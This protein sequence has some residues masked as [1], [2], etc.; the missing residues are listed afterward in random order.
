MCAISSRGY[1]FAR[2]GRR[3]AAPWF[4]DFRGLGIDKGQPALGSVYEGLR[5]PFTNVP[6]N[7]VKKGKFLLGGLPD[8][9]NHVVS[10]EFSTG[11]CCVLSFN[12]LRRR[13]V[14]SS[15]A[16]SQKVNWTWLGCVPC[17]AVAYSSRHA[18]LLRFHSGCNPLRYI[19]YL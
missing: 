18:L 6:A 10:T 14:D 3:K 5:P 1:A 12:W 16:C 8:L 4:S 15:L 9:H 19:I 11:R 13:S 7:K 17:C 2:K